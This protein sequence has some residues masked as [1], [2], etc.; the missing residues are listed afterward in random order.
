MS[1]LKIPD[2]EMLEFRKCQDWKCQIWKCQNFKN[3][4]TRGPCPEVTNQSGRKSQQFLELR[5]FRKIKNWFNLKLNL[6]RNWLLEDHLLQKC[7]WI[8][9]ILELS[10]SD[11]KLFW[12]WKW[13]W[14]DS[15]PVLKVDIGSTLVRSPNRIAGRHSEAVMKRIE[16]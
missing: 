1:E 13:I 5:K 15:G 14:V 6:E 3:F 2:L 4:Q 7:D 12:I 11:L 9:P 10:P 16:G 8:E